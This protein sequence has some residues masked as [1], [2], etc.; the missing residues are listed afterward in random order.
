MGL[1]AN[2]DQGRF[3]VTCSAIF[4]CCGFIPKIGALISAMP[5]AVLGDGVIIMFG[6]VVSAGINMLS[7]VEWDPRN[8]TILAIS[9]AV[10][11]G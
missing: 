4:P 2:W 1:V 6:M 5:I 10:G 8:M 7:D 11:L 3:V 9:L